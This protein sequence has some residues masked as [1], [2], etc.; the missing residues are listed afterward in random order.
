MKKCIFSVVILLLFLP[1]LHANAQGIYQFWGTMGIGGSQSVGTIYTTKSNGSNI[2]VQKNF[3]MTNPGNPMEFGRPVVYN[4]KFYCLMEDGGVDHAGIITEYN[5]LTDAWV[6]KAD[7]FSIA[8][9]QAQG[10]LLVYNNKLYGTCRGG[11]SSQGMIFE[12]DPVSSNLTVR[13]DFSNGVGATPTSGLTL[14]N[15]KFYGITQYEGV[16]GDGVIFEF[17][18]ANNSYIKK[19]DF[20]EATTGINYIGG[21]TV[22]NN[23]LW[24]VTNWGASS[25]CGALYFLRIGTGI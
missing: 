19:A 8:G 24:G 4:S 13:F 21:L 25:N 3:T 9:K 12:F 15:N 16:N 5:P 14:Y 11:L 20:L 17:N 7:L 18:P 2:A 22:Y 23:L 6:K 10:N 1:V